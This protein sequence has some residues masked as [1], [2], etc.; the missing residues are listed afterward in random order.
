MMKIN[1]LEFDYIN[2]HNDD[3]NDEHRM[4][5]NKMIHNFMKESEKNDDK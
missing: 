4:I 1:E 5:I 3:D 2:N